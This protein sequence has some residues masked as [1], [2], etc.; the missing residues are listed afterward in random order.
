MEDYLEKLAYKNENIKL[1]QKPP[2]K[3]EPQEEQKVS[4][5]VQDV[6]PEESPPK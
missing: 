2:V 5:Y 6:G 1:I 4:N 3:V